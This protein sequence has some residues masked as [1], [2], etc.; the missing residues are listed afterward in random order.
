MIANEE[1]LVKT[2]YLKIYENTHNKF[3]NFNLS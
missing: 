1:N 3:I 2:H